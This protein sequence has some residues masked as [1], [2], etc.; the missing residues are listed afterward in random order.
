MKQ[1]DMI[2]ELDL[3]GFFRFMQ[4]MLTFMHFMW[5]MSAQ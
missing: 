2:S 4:F 5:I 3:I 1:D